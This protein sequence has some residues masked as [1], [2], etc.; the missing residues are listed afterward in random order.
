EA[1]ID[2]ASPAQDSRPDNRSAMLK[3]LHDP[4]CLSGRRR[5]NET[6]ALERGFAF[7]SPFISNPEDS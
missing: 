5:S 2:E 4:I 3:A 7:L 6:S 1:P